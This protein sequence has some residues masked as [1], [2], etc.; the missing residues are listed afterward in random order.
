MRKTETCIS[1]TIRRV[2]LDAGAIP[3]SGPGL[4]RS[5]GIMNAQPFTQAER[6]PPSTGEADR[7]TAG[8]SN[9]LLIDARASVR[10]GLTRELRSRRMEPILIPPDLSGSGL[11][12]LSEGAGR[13]RPVLIADGEGASRTIALIRRSG[14]Q[15]PVL[16][17]QDFRRSDRTVEL[18]EAGAD[19][20]LTLPLR[21]AELEARITAIRRRAQGAAQGHVVIGPLIIPLDRRPPLLGGEVLVLPEAE[22]TLLRHLALHAGRPVSRDALYDLLYETSEAKPYLRILDRYVCN[23]RH[24]IAARWPGGGSVIRTLK[25]YG[26]A[27]S[28]EP[29]ARGYGLITG[30]ASEVFQ[31][32]SLHVQAEM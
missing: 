21:G 8:W 15:N 4:V 14:H 7:G 9:V 31:E 1:N 18:I 2:N 20:V 10:S 16:A 30:S 26:Y 32:Q 23:L 25:G 27:L 28:S 6:N 29:D 19:Q 22:V 13:R 11:A 3:R 5:F 24:R 12:P 17:Y